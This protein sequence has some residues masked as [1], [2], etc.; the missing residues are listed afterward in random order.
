MSTPEAEK[1]QRDKNQLSDLAYS[2][3]SPS[4]SHTHRIC[5]TLLFGQQMRLWARTDCFQCCDYAIAM[6]SEGWP[7]LLQV[8]LSLL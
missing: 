7:L 1:Y 4:L 8:T 2:H 6:G 3:L 5:V